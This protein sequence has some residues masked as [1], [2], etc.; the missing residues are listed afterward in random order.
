MEDDPTF[1]LVR[2][3]SDIQREEEL[4]AVDSS[5]TL[6][7]WI[8]DDCT[9]GGARDSAPTGRGGGQAE[10]PATPTFIVRYVPP[11]LRQGG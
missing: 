8:S 9:V 11:Y 10:V 1:L 7:P 2:V 3:H 4:V 6:R 5:F